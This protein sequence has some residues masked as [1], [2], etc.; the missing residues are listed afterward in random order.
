MDD[1]IDK[2]VQTLPLSTLSDTALGVDASHF[3]SQHFVD[4]STKEPLEPLVSAHGGLPILLQSSIEKQLDVLLANQITPIFV[5]DG[6][7]FPQRSTQS[8]VNSESSRLFDTAWDLYN[9]D[10][11]EQAVAT[12]SASGKFGYV[13]NHSG[14]VRSCDIH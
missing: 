4:L 3:L 9:R 5:F 10:E 6:L 1:W 12:F 14:L 13:L 7:D 2:R 8:G 11:R